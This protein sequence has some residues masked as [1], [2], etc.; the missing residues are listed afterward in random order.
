MLILVRYDRGFHDITVIDISDV[1]ISK[2]MEKYKDCNGLYFQTMN[3]TEMKGLNSDDYDII[4]DKGTMDSLLIS[5]SN[6]TGLL[7]YIS[8]IERLLK[9]SGTFIEITYGNP[10]MRAVY[11]D[12]SK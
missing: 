7:S 11:F 12:R 5:L 8:E 2:L 9:Y 4:I 3:C 10:Q 1:V 6:V